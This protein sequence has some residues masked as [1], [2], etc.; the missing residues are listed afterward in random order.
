MKLEFILFFGSIEA[1]LEA[2][3]TWAACDFNTLIVTCE[4]NQFKLDAGV[5]AGRALKVL[6][7]CLKLS[8]LEP[9]K[10]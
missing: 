8:D 3:N 4:L 6:F 9:Y 1:Q 7:D 5:C 10:S 2:D